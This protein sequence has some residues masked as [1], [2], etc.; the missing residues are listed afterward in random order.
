MSENKKSFGYKTGKAHIALRQDGY[1]VW[2]LSTIK[3]NGKY[4]MF[5]SH[6]KENLGFGRNWLYNSEIVRWNYMITTN[7]S[8]VILSSGKTYMIYKSRCTFG[9]PL[10]FG[11][12]V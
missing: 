4:H 10:Q 8:I 2:N 1:Y 3:A 5:A 11:I 12:A 9:K 7:S 6:W